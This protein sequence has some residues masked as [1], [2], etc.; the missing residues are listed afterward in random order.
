MH[1][2]EVADARVYRRDDVRLPL[3]LEAEVADEGG[4]EDRVDRGAVV[5]GPLVHPA[6]AG[7]RGRS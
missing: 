7:A 5:A 4:V 6:D 2:E 3:P 1:V